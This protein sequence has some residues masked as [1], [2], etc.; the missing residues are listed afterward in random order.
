MIRKIHFSYIS[1][2]I[3]R[4][5]FVVTLSVSM[6]FLSNAQPTNFYNGGV[7]IAINPSTILYVGGHVINEP[8]GFIHNQ[9]DIY[10][11]GDWTNNEPSGCLD[12]T[13]G[14]VILYG[15]SQ[16]IQGTQT[17]KFNNLDCQGSGTK[18]LNIKT[19]VGGNTGILSLNFSPFNLN[20]KLCEVTNPSSTAITRT[21]GYIVS[22]TDPLAGYGTL[23]WNI[24]NSTGNYTIPFGTLSG[25]Y[26]P[27][28]YNVNTNG[29]QTVTGNIA[30]AT[31]PT[32]VTSS[33]NNRPLP[34]GV[35]DLNDASAV[36]RAESCVDRFWITDINNYSTNPTADI[37]FTYRDLEWNTTGGSTNNIVEDSLRAWRWDGIQWQNPPFG[38]LDL[39]ANTVS[40]TGIDYSAAWT[41][42][43]RD[44]PPEACGDYT[45]P[46]AFSP[47]NDGHNDLFVLRG[48]LNNCVSDFS[49]NVFDRWGEKVFESNDPSKSW[50]GTFR[51]K[52]L[53]P[54]V[55][56]YFIN[57]NVNG[58]DKIH[59]KGNISLIR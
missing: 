35:L 29:S 7:D 50:D 11:T 2:A 59:K 25:T 36:D 37:T 43:S 17:T 53:D 54:N 40:L 26:I 13:T 34:A 49:L 44:V 6:S 8:S 42:K 14:T 31:Y 23:Q 52:T 3:L 19:I 4:F 16:L 18:T 10:L 32:S 45:V 41:L 51:G 28:K 58:G 24:G 15:A 1:V 20:S 30:L 5:V 21:S 27:V 12:P 38:Q 56:V 39:A 48:W 33:P 47:N 22:E 9:G 46:N 55:F 57:A